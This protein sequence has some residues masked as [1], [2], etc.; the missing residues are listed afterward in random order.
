[1]MAELIEYESEPEVSTTLRDKRRPGRREDVSPHL[2][3]LLRGN[4][5]PVPDALPEI[6]ETDAQ[7]ADVFVEPDRRTTLA[8]ARGV[9][10]GVGLGSLIWGCIGAGFWYYFSG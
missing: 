10:L 7:P 2:I 6:A 4:G 9:F 3:P 8:A 1:M 5:A